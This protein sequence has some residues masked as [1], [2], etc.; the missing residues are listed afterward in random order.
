[1]KNAATRV[2]DP[3]LAC[4]GLTATPDRLDGPI[5]QF[6]VIRMDSG[7]IGRHTGEPR[8]EI[9]S[10]NPAG[11]IRPLDLPALE[12]PE[13]AANV[14]NPLRLRQH[15]ALL[16]QLLLQPLAVGDI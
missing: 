3:T 14:R 2:Q 9:E 7:H 11:L 16:L 1:M 13:P 5:H 12:M 10:E 8:C 4:R 15:V 6:L